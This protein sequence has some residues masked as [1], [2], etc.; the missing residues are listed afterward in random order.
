[1]SYILWVQRNKK[2]Y[3]MR[4]YIRACAYWLENNFTNSPVSK[5]KVLQ[6]FGI[7]LSLCLF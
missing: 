3:M 5:G 4:A 1:M 6:S 7:I 2:I